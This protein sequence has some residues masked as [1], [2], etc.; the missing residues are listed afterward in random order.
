MFLERLTEHI[1]V[2]LASLQ[3]LLLNPHIV[4][5]QSSLKDNPFN[6]SLSFFLYVQLYNAPMNDYHAKLVLKPLAF[7]RKW[8]LI[9]E[10]LYQDVQLVSKK[11][12]VTKFLNLQVCWLRHFSF[13]LLDIVGV[14]IA[15][16]NHSRQELATA[17]CFTRR[18]GSGS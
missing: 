9:Y 17:F 2:F 6:S 14:Y 10:P 12:P 1:S 7:E 16:H 18:V 15:D 4:K 3:S 11:I 8:K 13:C 5:Y